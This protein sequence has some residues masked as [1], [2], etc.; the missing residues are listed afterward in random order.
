MIR[1]IR[2]LVVLGHQVTQALQGHREQRHLQ[3]IAEHQVIQVNL[4]QRVVPGHRV[5]RE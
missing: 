2:V 3:G 4:A 1:V 5:I